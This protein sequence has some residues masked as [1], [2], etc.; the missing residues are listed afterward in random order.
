MTNK[1]KLKDMVRRKKMGY[2]PEGLSPIYDKNGRITPETR[3]LGPEYLKDVKFI[4]MPPSKTVPVKKKKEQPR[5]RNI[6]NL[7]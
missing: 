6:R 2:N 7:A 1:D 3:G 4:K 5:I